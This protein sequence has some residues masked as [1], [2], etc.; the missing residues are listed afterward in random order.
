MTGISYRACQGIAQDVLGDDSPDHTTIYRRINNL[1]IKLNSDKI[2]CDKDSTILLSTDSSG[3]QPNERGEWLRVKWSV[4]RGFIKIHFLINVKTRK[5]LAVHVTTDEEGDAPQFKKLLKSA[6]T[7]IDTIKKNVVI[8]ADGAYD[9][10]ENFKYCAANNVTPR[11]KVRIDSQIRY[12]H[13][14]RN[15]IVCEQLG[16]NKNSKITEISINK[17]KKNRDRWKKKSTLW[18]AMD[19]QSCFFIL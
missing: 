19:I 2:P 5:I 6:L 15:K 1:E 14:A 18:S 7:Q 8:Y 10:K 9:S 3:V 11:I 4:Q 17:R 12:G 16:R 13:P